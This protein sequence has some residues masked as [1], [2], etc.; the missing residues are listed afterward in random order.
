M[1]GALERRSSGG[2]T[3][4]RR[5]PSDLRAAPAIIARPGGHALAVSSQ[6]RDVAPGRVPPGR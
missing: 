4:S 5:I 1:S 3:D 6:R 2:L